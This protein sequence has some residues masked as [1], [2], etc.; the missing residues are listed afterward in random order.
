MSGVY[1]NVWQMC[2][3]HG[4]FIYGH[5]CIIKSRE[6]YK[7]RSVLIINSAHLDAF[8][9]GAPSSG[10]FWLLSQREYCKSVAVGQHPVR[11]LTVVASW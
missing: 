7:G 11:S 6:I 3:V 4:S 1:G 2:V 5:K 9:R 10:G 8:R